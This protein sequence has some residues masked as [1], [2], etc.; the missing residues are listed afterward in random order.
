MDTLT[1]NATQ[2]QRIRSGC[3]DVDSRNTNRSKKM[4][5]EKI[6]PTVCALKAAA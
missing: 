1:A 4:K 3:A 5:I 6:T 2:F